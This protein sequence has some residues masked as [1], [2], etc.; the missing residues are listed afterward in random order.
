MQP[1][2]NNRFLAALA[3]AGSLCL[4][5][6]TAP[7]A[8]RAQEQ[9]PRVAEARAHFEAGEGHYGAGRYALAAQEFQRSH[10][11]LAAAQH[12]NAA[13]VLFNVGRSLMELGGHDQEARDA[14]ARFLAEA[15]VS[16]ETTEM[17][18]LA[19]QHMRELDVRLGS[20]STGAA[21]TTSARSGGSI[22]P[23]G[24][25]LLG[26]GGA[27][28]VAG[29]I[30]GGAALGQY[31]DLESMCSDGRCPDSARGPADVVRTTTIVADVMLFG[32]LV[33]AA[34]GLVLT[35]VL[36]EGESSDQAAVSLSCGAAGCEAEFRGTF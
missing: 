7:L 10:E 21:S 19:Q 20:A 25:I 11:L 1:C 17:I 33:V 36:T 16:G 6:A 35:L 26:V 5:S 23:V 3:V 15:P 8:A 28:L 30:S 18:S 24:P 31:G 29:A 4:F 9:D 27:M 14:Y 12:H 22:S 32:G 2:S 34:A 13:L